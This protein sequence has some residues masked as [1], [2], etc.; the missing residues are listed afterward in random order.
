MAF[1]FNPPSSPTLNQVYSPADGFNWIWNGNQWE[2]FNP[3]LSVAPVTSGSFNAGGA[4]T[5]G[6][7]G[8]TINTITPVKPQFSLVNTIGTAGQFLTTDGVTGVWSSPIFGPSVAK[9][10]FMAQF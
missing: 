5:F 10:Y 8:I 4:A 2:P 9:T 6:T 1:N 7:N 3:A